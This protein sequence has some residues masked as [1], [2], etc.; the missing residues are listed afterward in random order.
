MEMRFSAKEKIVESFLILTLLLIIGSLITALVA[1]FI[2]VACAPIGH[3][4]ETAADAAKAL[5]PLAGRF[6][7]G[8]F[9]F[10]LLNVVVA[11]WAVKVFRGEIAAG[12]WIK[13]QCLAAAAALWSDP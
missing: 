7:S 12:G 5:Q 11:L 3:S 9:A 10:G 1:F 8:L 2:I 6:A 13:G 4:I